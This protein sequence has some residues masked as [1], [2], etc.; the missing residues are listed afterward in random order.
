MYQFGSGKPQEDFF[1]AIRHATSSVYNNKDYSKQLNILSVLYIRKAFHQLKKREDATIDKLC[2][3]TDE[4]SKAALKEKLQANTAIRK[5]ILSAWRMITHKDKYV[6]FSL[7]SRKKIEPEH[8]TKIREVDKALSPVMNKAT[9]MVV[10]CD[11]MS[12]SHFQAI[13][14]MITALQ[15]VLNNCEAHISFRHAIQTA[16][17][18]KVTDLKS[19]ENDFL[20]LV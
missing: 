6:G 5:A 16:L 15:V 11:K 12:S 7:F 1:E 14:V 9:Q 4:T 3:L 19:I 20:K 17:S 2:Q 10:S 18:A 8:W 13:L